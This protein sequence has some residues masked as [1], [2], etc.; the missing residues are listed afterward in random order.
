MAEIYNIIY[1]L[2]VVSASLALN[3][4]ITPQSHYSRVYS[5]LFS[6][7]QV[8][9]G[10]FFKRRGDFLICLLALPDLPLLLSLEDLLSQT[11]L[12]APNFHLDEILKCSAFP[13]LPNEGI[14]LLLGTHYLLFTSEETEPHYNVLNLIMEIC[15][16]QY[17]EKTQNKSSDLFISHSLV[18]CQERD[19]YSNNNRGTESK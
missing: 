12:A 9:R 4:T 16:F 17:H 8:R 13:Q 7:G 14:I 10:Y 18:L 2:N 15:Y 6:C 11:L 1:F 19:C 3:K 5:S